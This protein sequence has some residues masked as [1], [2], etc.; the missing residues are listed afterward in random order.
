M[1]FHVTK[2]AERELDQIFVYYAQRAGVDVADR[3]IDSIEERF[4]L[5]GDYPFVG[6][7][8]DDLAQG[9]FRF[10][11]GEYLIYYRKKR[12]MIQIIHVL[13]GA[14]DQDRAFRNN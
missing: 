4:A 5:L 12:G 7:K 11:A 6:R 9:V 3:L 14:R 8:V 2:M 1:Q 13:H 10:P